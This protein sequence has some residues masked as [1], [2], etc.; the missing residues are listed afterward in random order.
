MTTSTSSPAAGRLHCATSFWMPLSASSSSI[1]RPVS[2]GR[3]QPPRSSS[4]DS[5]PAVKP[6][7]TGTPATWKPGPARPEGKV[8]MPREAGSASSGSGTWCAAATSEAACGATVC[9]RVH[10]ARTGVTAKPDTGIHSGGRVAPTATESG[11][12]AS[13]SAASRSAVATA[14]ASPGSAAPPGERDLA[15]MVAERGGPLLQQ[16]RGAVVVRRRP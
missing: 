12:T 15:G 8:T 10:S 7:I 2:Q 6:Q 11:S 5:T 14:S 4:H 16:D 1:V 13:S 3:V 9:G